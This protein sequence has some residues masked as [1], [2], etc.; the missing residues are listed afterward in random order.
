MHVQWMS[1]NNVAV[2][3]RLEGA[4]DAARVLAGAR[5]R[6]RDVFCL[7]RLLSPRA[8]DLVARFSFTRLLLRVCLFNISTGPGVFI[9]LKRSCND[10]LFSQLTA[11][12]SSALDYQTSNLSLQL[13]CSIQAHV[14]NMKKHV[15]RTRARI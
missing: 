7:S 1:I 12:I 8:H 13:I 15:S 10:N 5:A 3:F 9:L 14:L 11:L 6:S 2:S 4:L